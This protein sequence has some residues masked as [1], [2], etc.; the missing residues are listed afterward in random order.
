MDDT[1]THHL[2]DDEVSVMNR[3]EYSKQC[4]IIEDTINGCSNPFTTTVNGVSYNATFKR[5]TSKF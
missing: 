1:L 2:K 3:D 4:R 5:M